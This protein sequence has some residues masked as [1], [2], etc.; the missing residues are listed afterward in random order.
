MAKLFFSTILS[1]FLVSSCATQGSLNVDNRQ[2]NLTPFNRLME[3][4][5]VKQLLVV[6]TVAGKTKVL[7]TSS[8]ENP[9]VVVVH[10]MGGQGNPIFAEKE[11]LPTTKK[12]RNPMYWFGAAFLEKKVAWAAIDVPA[13]F[14]I[15]LPPS[16]RL[17]HQH[18]EAFAQAARQIRFVYPKA[19][20]VLIG[21]S[22]GGITAGMQSVQ[23]K[24][25]FDAIVFASPNLGGLPSGWNPEQAKVPILFITHEK[26]YCKATL[27]YNTIRTAGNRFPI[28]VIK[29][30]ASGPFSECWNAPAPHFFSGVQAE[31]ADAVLRWANNIQ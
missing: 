19:K 22:N 12:I 26:D 8:T 27:A 5:S 21:H 4:A 9:Q 10:A 25:V 13:D 24:P 7:L 30:P 14:G 6:D 31:F 29:S 17:T 16:A 11:G 23:P 28:I 1:I 15:E 20:L 18:I 3:L 2:E